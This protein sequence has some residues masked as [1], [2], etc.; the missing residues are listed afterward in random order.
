MTEDGDGLREELRWEAMEVLRALWRHQAGSK[1]GGIDRT[2]CL[3]T[4]V[5]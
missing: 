4:K 5:P 1:S 2:K 3:K